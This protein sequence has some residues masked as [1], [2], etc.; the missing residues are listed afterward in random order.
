MP[1]HIMCVACMHA[2]TADGMLQWEWQAVSGE[3]VQVL[4]QLQSRLEGMPQP[5]QST[6]H[7]HRMC[8]ALAPPSPDATGG[9]AQRFPDNCFDGDLLVCCDHAPKAWLLCLARC[10]CLL[11]IVPHEWGFAV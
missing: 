11:V 8:W 2:T 6:G 7:S 5:R 4:Q 10:C 1:I 3:A 9:D